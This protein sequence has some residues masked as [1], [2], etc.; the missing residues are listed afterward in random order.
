VDAVTYIHRAREI[1]FQLHYTNGVLDAEILELGDKQNLQFVLESYFSK[2]GI[3][4]TEIPIGTKDCDNLEYDTTHEFIPGSLSVW[5][6]GDKLVS[7][8]H[9][10]EK[11]DRQGF[12][13][14]LSPNVYIGLHT[15]PNGFE[16]LEVTYDRRITFNT[17]G[18]T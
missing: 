5:L 14:I 17:K 10:L 3:P 11:L 8:I 13:L 2:V 15:P 12:T 18:G 6:G 9:Y 4:V 7:G 16:T 1:I